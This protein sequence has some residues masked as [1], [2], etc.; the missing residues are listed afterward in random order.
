[1]DVRDRKVNSDNWILVRDFRKEGGAT[2]VAMRTFISGFV[3]A[4]TKASGCGR[5]R[6]TKT[7]GCYNRNGPLQ[8]NLYNRN[9]WLQNPL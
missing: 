6:T 1:M 7:G 4:K 8:K 5:R 3:E 2:D 9:G